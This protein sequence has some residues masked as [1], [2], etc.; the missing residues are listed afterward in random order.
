MLAGGR[1]CGRHCVAQWCVLSVASGGLPTVSLEARQR[2]EK[3]QAM[4]YT[5][6]AVESLKFAIRAAA[7]HRQCCSR[8]RIRSRRSFTA[9]VPQVDRVVASRLDGAGHEQLL[10]K[11]R[12][13]EYEEC[14][15]EY[16]AALWPEDQ[17]AV[18]AFRARQQPITKARCVQHVCMSAIL[19]ACGRFT[20]LTCCWDCAPVYHLMGTVLIAAASRVVSTMQASRLPAMPQHSFSKVCILIKS[21]PLCAFHSFRTLKHGRKCGAPPPPAEPP[22]RPQP[23]PRPPPMAAAPTV[24]GQVRRRLPHRPP[25]LHHRQLRPRQRERRRHRRRR[26]GRRGCTVA[27]RA[28]SRRHRPGWR[29]PYTTTSW[30]GSTG[31]CT[32]GSRGPTSSWRTRWVRLVRASFCFFL[33]CHGI[34]S[35]VS[36][37]H[38]NG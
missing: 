25:L 14:T 19:H 1:C 17:E 13:L 9:S 12:A 16:E 35:A 11:W 29:V 21:S 10:V 22:R 24:P 27:A 36:G 33:L 5:A 7:H 6:V 26:W 34:V 18:M 15:W 20:L 2:L 23:L 30:R 38:N 32:A 31:W 28:S 3:A 8:R 37:M 4:A